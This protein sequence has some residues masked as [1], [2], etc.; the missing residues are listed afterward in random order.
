M[1]AAEDKGNI[2]IQ[3]S[4]VIIAKSLRFIMQKLF[5]I[6]ILFIHIQIRSALRNV[7]YG[8]GHS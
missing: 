1:K 8:S 5:L 6:T 3:Y 7:P 4:V 2:N